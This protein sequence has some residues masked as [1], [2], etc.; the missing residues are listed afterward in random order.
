MIDGLT[1]DYAAARAAARLAWRPDDRLW[2]RLHAARGLR[3]LLDTARAAPVGIYVSG[4]AATASAGEIDAAFRAQWRARVTELSGWA[5]ADWRPA[6]RW[7]ATLI[8]LPAVAALWNGE[9]ARWMQTDPLLAR[10]A[11]PPGSPAPTRAALHV[12]LIEG[13]L[14]P[15]G[16]AL[17]LLDAEPAREHRHPGA[18]QSLPATLRAWR[19]HWRALWPATDADQHAAL[20]ALEHDVLAHRARFAQLPAT[21]T[22][23]ARDAFAARMLARLRADPSQPPALFAWLLVLAL[24]LE[25]LRAEALLRALELPLPAAQPAAPARAPAEAA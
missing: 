7:C 10:Y 16:R 21:D 22:Q 12:A 13:P 17:F 23:A 14:A 11:G 8:D 4:I 6:L 20:D 25:R 2:Q 19:Q 9:R 5:P 15:L 1:L 24:D 3:A 18:E